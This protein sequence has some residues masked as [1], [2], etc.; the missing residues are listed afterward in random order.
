MKLRCY[1]DLVTVHILTRICVLFRFSPVDLRAGVKYVNV[2]YLDEQQP[3]LEEHGQGPAEVVRADEVEQ[4]E[5]D[6]QE[7]ADVLVIEKLPKPRPSVRQ[8]QGNT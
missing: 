1:S 8:E 6:P 5:L 3:D 4:V 2:E 7:N